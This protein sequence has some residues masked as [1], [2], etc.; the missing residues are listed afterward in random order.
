MIETFCRPLRNIVVFGVF[1]G[2]FLGILGPFLGILGPFLG[3]L[4][5]FLGILGPFWYFSTYTLHMS[6][7]RLPFH[8]PSAPSLRSARVSPPR[9]PPTG[10]RRLFI[11]ACGF[12]SAKSRP[13]PRRGEH[14][15]TM[16]SVA[17]IPWH[18]DTAKR[19]EGAAVSKFGDATVQPGG[20]SNR[21]GHIAIKHF[22]FHHI[23]KP[24]C[25]IPT[26]TLGGITP[27]VYCHENLSSLVESYPEFQAQELDQ[28]RLRAVE[29]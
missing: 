17:T 7:H 3:I 2:P 11:R 24:Y 14:P 13:A 12:G 28:M 15:V 21:M 16:E 1:L 25:I 19:P 18:H 4:G 9:P 6:P 29:F 23:Y 20:G 10:P 22:R 5:P 8:P 27:R 26:T